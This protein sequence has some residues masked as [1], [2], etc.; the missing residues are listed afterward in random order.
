M[1][2]PAHEEAVQIVLARL[3]HLVKVRAPRRSSPPAHRRPAHL[4]P[5]RPGIASTLPAPPTLSTPTPVPTPHADSTSHAHAS[6]WQT[7]GLLLRQPFDDYMKNVNSPKQIDEVTYVQF[8]NGLGRTGLEVSGDETELIA[9]KFPGKAKVASHTIQPNPNPS[10]SPGPNLTLPLTRAT[11]TTW[12]SCAP[13]TRASASSLHASPGP[14]CSPPTS[15]TEASVSR[16]RCWARTSRAGWPRL[17]TGLRSTRR[18]LTR[19]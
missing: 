10:P 2:P 9:L 12:P 13:S 16:A 18:P 17:L 5:P 7:K 8:R 11:S 14:T 19:T 6:I 1:L 15:C 3:A 4:S